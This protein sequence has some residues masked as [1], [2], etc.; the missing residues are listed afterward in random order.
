MRPAALL[1]GGYDGSLS[2]LCSH[3]GEVGRAGGK[4]RV[5]NSK[6][7]VG[8][9]GPVVAKFVRLEQFHRNRNG[10]YVISFRFR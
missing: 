2:P 6:N 5:L 10:G 3:H 9:R 1:V 8:G 4:V 7:Y